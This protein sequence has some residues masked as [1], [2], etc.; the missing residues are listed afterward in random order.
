VHLEG[1]DRPAA[2]APLSLGV[3]LE[4]VLGSLSDPR[5]RRIPPTAHTGAISVRAAMIPWRP[6]MPSEIAPSTTEPAKPP[7]TSE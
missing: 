1:G 2:L 3:P 4:D 7:K 5:T 6:P